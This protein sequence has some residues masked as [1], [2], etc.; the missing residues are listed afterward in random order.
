MQLY[1]VF[2]SLICIFA[3]LTVLL[4]LNQNAYEKEKSKKRQKVAQLVNF[5]YLCSDETE[6]HSL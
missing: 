3:A 6:N 5:L 2:F 4:Y 1:F